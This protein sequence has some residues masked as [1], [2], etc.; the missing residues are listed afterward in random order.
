MMRPEWS[1][2]ACLKFLGRPYV[3]KHKVLTV[4]QPFAQLTWLHVLLFIYGSAPGTPRPIPHIMPN[5]RSRRVNRP[6]ALPVTRLEGGGPWSHELC[7]ARP[8]HR[9]VRNRAHG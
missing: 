4:V 6:H 3:E 2:S 5:A 7:A 1:S 9:T 8:P